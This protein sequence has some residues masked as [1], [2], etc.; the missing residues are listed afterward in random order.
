MNQIVVRSLAK[1][2][3]KSVTADT[4]IYTAVDSDRSTDIISSRL[5]V[6]FADAGVLSINR[7]GVWE[8]LNGGVALTAG[9]LYGFD[10]GMYPD[11]V[12]DIKYS[13]TTTAQIYW[14]WRIGL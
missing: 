11:V 13:A 3:N 14:Y 6:S 1:D 5:E 12:Y 2:K 8:T 9:A 7:N 10:I 4:A